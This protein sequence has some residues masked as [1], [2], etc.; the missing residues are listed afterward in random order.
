MLSFVIAV[1]L[2]FHQDR[3]KALSLQGFR[4]VASKMLRP[5]QDRPKALSIQHFLLDLIYMNK[6]RSS[7]LCVLE[8]RTV[9]YRRK[10]L[11]GCVR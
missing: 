7:L 2:R 1:E 4:K 5:H 3:P 8:V 11:P 10:L 6:V 9:R